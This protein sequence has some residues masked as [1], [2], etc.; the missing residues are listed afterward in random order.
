MQWNCIKLYHHLPFP[1]SS[2]P[3]PGEGIVGEYTPHSFPNYIIFNVHE[4]T[5]P[6]FYTDVTC[7]QTKV[8]INKAVLNLL[9]LNWVLMVAIAFLSHQL[10]YY[11]SNWDT[12]CRFWC[13][14][15]INNSNYTIY[16]SQRALYSAYEGCSK[17]G[18]LR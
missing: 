7:R 6:E 18:T 10:S 3:V 11:L 9:H 1:P 4:P 5:N 17:P 13:L 15:Y 12:W 14:N 2:T 8:A 16:K